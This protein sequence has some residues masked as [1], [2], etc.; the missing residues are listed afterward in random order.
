MK[1]T[2]IPY[3][4]NKHLLLGISKGREKDI[5]MDTLSACDYI[6]TMTE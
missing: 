1:K 5:E 4:D 2:F 6:D 3:L